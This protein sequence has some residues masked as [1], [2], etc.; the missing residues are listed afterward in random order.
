MNAPSSSPAG[1]FFGWRLVAALGAI[2]FFM[3]GTGLYSF[4]VYIVA[5][6]DEFGWTMTEISGGAALFA[7][8][9]G[10]GG[11]LVGISI[12]RLGAR[13]TMLGGAAVAVLATLVYSRIDSLWMLYLATC[14][15]G[16]GVA[17]TTILPAQTLVTNWFDLYRG[18]AL[19]T[20]MLGIGFGGL[21]LPPW[22]EF[23]IRTIG[24]RQAWLV[25]GAVVVTVVIPLIAALVRTRPSDLGLHADG[26]P[27]DHP[28]HADGSRVVAGLSVREATATRD[29]WLVVGV[30]IAQLIG[31][32]A[33][34]FH[35]VPFAIKQAGFTSQEAALYFGFTV[36]FSIFGRLGFGWAVDRYNPKWM[37]VL[38]GSLLAVGPLVVE[39]L[40]VRMQVAEAAW[41]LAYAVPFG[42]GIGG[43]A[44]VMPVLVG[45]CF[46][47]LHFSKIM[48]LVM[49]GFAVGILVGI[50]AGGNIYDRTGSYELVL[51]LASCTLTVSALLAALVEP[52]RHRAAFATEAA[53]AMV[54]VD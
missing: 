50:P 40:L 23:L 33:M 26:L 3:A 42:I 1:S 41:M 11:P 53:P 27:N 47:A 51:I 32:S 19:A 15:F 7:I 28:S 18:R 39:V 34:N 25:N 36:G 29:F 22:N 4:P 24:W 38:T 20:A 48:G 52:D 46:G 54:G 37:M 2:L 6:Q 9:M 45:R 17:G 5:F 8:V 43:N 13:P 30:F 44:V 10:V 16:A 49:S 31:V 21:A 35:F 12:A 14:S